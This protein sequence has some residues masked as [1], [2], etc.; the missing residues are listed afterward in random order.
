MNLTLWSSRFRMVFRQPSR[1]LPKRSSLHTNR[2][3]NFLAHGVGHEG[4]F[5]GWARQPRNSAP[6]CYC[7]RLYVVPVGVW[8]A[9]KC[10]GC[11][12]PCDARYQ[13]LPQLMP[14]TVDRRRCANG[15]G[16]GFVRLSARSRR[17]PVLPSPGL[18]SVSVRSSRGLTVHYRAVAATSIC[19]QHFRL[20]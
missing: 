11:G 10:S 7:V 2:H 12:T 15:P 4:G 20:W 17:S 3:S 18:K 6:R 1:D 16:Y 5:Q 14:P 19:H 8:D 13:G 9:P